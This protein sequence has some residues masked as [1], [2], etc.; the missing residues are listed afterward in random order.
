VERR[1]GD[2][3]V[4]AGV[5]GL[6]LALHVATAPGYG[7]FRDELYYLACADR[8]D[9]GYVDH[10]PLSI[11]LL[12]FWRLLFGDGLFALR[13]L[14]GVA[15]AATVFLTGLIA[16]EL[17]GGRAAQV[18]AALCAFF[19]PFFLAVSHFY[20]MNAFDL[21]AWS[22]LWWLAVRI[23]VRDEPRLWLVFGLIAGLGLEN[24]YSVGFLGFGLVLGLAFTAQR[25][26]LRSA[27]LWAGGALAGLLFAP[28]LVWQLAHGWP[29]LEFMRNASAL[30]NEPIGPLDFLGGQLVLLHPLLAPLW[31]LGL[32]ALLFGRDFARVRAL[33]LA[34]L[35]ILALMLLTN[36]KIYYLAPA[37]SLLFAAGAVSL[38]AFFARRAWRNTPVV[39]GVAIVAAGLALVPMT[40][41][42]LPPET[43]IA[44]SRAIGLGV[45]KMERGKRA[46]LG[47]IY[48]DMFGW[49]ELAEEVARVW[50]AL[51]EHERPFAVIVGRNYGEA[52]AIDYFGRAHGLPRAI[53][54]HNSYGLWG[55]GDWD[56][57][58]A[59]VIGEIPPEIALEFGS[60]E[61][62]GHRSC[63]LCVPFESELSIYVV[64][65]LRIPVSE[66]WARIK[67]FI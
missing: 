35:A 52:G 62:L 67:R 21:V 39:A 30:K 37:Y 8:L 5:A 16:R 22:A 15:G 12:A 44:Y 40:I 38:D 11:A 46:E 48:A 31:G 34:Y 49:R 27:W 6:R 32:F 60:I 10:P 29:S 19:A 24:K 7:I 28:H 63:P 42:V 43:F 26:Q 47:E 13:F 33:G 57:H 65:D 45:P 41:P 1:P 53:S 50:Q 4:L 3:A 64:R 18:L 55:P 58:V 36:A 2:L 54:P 17:G 23:L 59:V 20:S 14:P 9:F 51:P 56:G 66:L 25:R 61:K